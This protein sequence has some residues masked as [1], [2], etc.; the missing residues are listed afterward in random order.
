MLDGLY[1]SISPKGGLMYCLFFW[2]S[3]PATLI[4]P[5]FHAAYE[6]KPHATLQCARQQY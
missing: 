6:D 1:E 2:Q 4:R 5:V 3:V